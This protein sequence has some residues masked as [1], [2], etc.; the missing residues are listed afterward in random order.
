VV[1]NCYDCQK[2]FALSPK[3]AEW[4]HE[5]GLSEP[6]RCQECR[7]T[8]RQIEDQTIQCFICQTEFVWSADNQRALRTYKGLD[9]N[10]IPR[11][12]PECR[13]K[14]KEIEDK[15]YYCNWC[16]FPFTFTPI[17]QLLYKIRGWSHPS[18]CEDCRKREKDNK[19]LI[20]DIYNARG[21]LIGHSYRQGNKTKRYN[22]KGKL[23][24]Y[25][26]HYQDY[27]IRYNARG[28]SIARSHRKNGR[29]EYYND[30][31]ELL[32]RTYHHT[33]YSEHFSSSGKKIGWSRIAS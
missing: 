18:R 12:C 7:D 27:S 3:E 29:S 11:V 20:M 32:S 6:E 5:H 13:N 24:D 14:I 9:N 25:W 33:K 4:Y 30:R 26:V 22:L 19:P 17:Q 16:H 21:E 15:T 28:K 10:I 2:E 8:R 1:K 31:G 23:T